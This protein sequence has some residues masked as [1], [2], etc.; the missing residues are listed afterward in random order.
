ME[1]FDVIVAG[2]GGHG[3]AAVM[4]LAS[5]GARVLGLER[6]SIPNERGSSHGVNRI[7]RLAYAEDPRYVP[8]LRRAYER[9]RELEKSVGEQL[10]WITG[11]IDAGSPDSEHVKGALESARVH[12]L[13][14]DV[15]TAT[16]LQR[17]FPGYSLPDGMI[18]MYQP[19][20]GF[21][22]SERAIVAHVNQA[23][24]HGAEI[25]AHEPI[26]GWRAT[27][28]GVEVE[29]AHGRYQA[30]QLVVTAG[31]W[32]GKTVPELAPVFKPQ[33]QVL[34]WTQPTVPASFALGSFPVFILDSP[35]GLFYGFPV[36]GI[37]GFKIGRYHHRDETIDPDVFDRDAFTTRDEEVLRAGI[38][39]Y[40]PD[41]N[42]PTLSLASCIFTNTADE[43]FV[44]DRLPGAPPVLVVSPCSGHGYK[45]T[46]VM[47]EIVADLVLDGGSRFDLSMFLLDR[48]LADGATA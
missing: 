19:D 30:K 22:A 33:R 39:R 11:G 23:L 1:R 31:A 24:V 29:T 14:H 46:S 27:D 28:D 21:V 3:S 35:E 10:L 18:G 9:W 7:I 34:I 4:E 2:V 25:H 42:G 5:R 8:L 40:F 32:V 44:I 20:S 48:L 36:F 17:R 41:A 6:S 13:P 37:P 45:F 15:L 12:D 26:T 16:E 38:S 47:G 43:H